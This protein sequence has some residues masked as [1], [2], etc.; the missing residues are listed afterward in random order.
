MEVDRHFFLVT[1]L[2]VGFEISSYL[3]R[4]TRGWTEVCV[5]VRMPEDGFIGDVTF[6]L[7]VE[8]RDGTASMYK[9]KNNSL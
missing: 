1:G 2:V 3:V 5:T 9:N 8:T 6:N 7:T 4:E